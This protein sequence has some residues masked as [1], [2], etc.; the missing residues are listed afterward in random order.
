MNK[1]KVGDIVYDTFLEQHYFLDGL[2]WKRSSTRA[3]TYTCL[4]TGYRGMYSVYNI[5]RFNF[6]SKVV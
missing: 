4:E 5:N 3:F 1:Y 2:G 6:I